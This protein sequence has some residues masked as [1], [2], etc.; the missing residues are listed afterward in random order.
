MWVEYTKGMNPITGWYCW[1]KSGA[2]TL[3]CC[4]HVASVIWYLRQ[5]RN[6]IENSETKPNKIHIVNVKHA[7][8]DTWSTSS[9]SEEDE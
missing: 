3:G 9:D 7:S 6:E 1:C 5:Y 8:V 2:S 4:A